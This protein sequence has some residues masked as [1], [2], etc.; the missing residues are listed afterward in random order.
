MATSSS[1]QLSPPIAARISE[2]ESQL[3]SLRRAE[4]QVLNSRAQTQA[5]LDNI[6]H[7]AWMKNTEGV[8]LAVNE[9]YAR[10]CGLPLDAVLG[11]TDWD[12][13]PPEL[14][15]RYVADDQRVM[16]SGQKVLVEEP[17]AWIDGTRWFETFKTPVID[18][19]QRVVGTV[20][21]AIDIT[22][23]RRAE[24]ERRILERQTLQA[25][26]LESL[27]LLAG[28]IA[29]DFNNLLTG[30]LTNA[31]LALHHLATS[32]NL[33]EVASRVADLKLAALH[34]SELTQQM[35]AYSGRGRFTVETL[36]LN[37]MVAEMS[38]LLRSSISKRAELRLDLDEQLP[39]VRADVAQLRQVIMNLLT[40]ASDAL[41]DEPGRI[42]IRTSAC[43]LDPSMWGSNDEHALPRG[44]Y[45]KLVVRDEG[46]GMDEITRAR[47]FEPFYT[48]KTT[49][50]GLG[51]SA[52]QGIV[53]GHGGGILVESAT[54]EGTTIT[55]LLPAI[56]ATAVRAS[57]PSPHAPEPS[58]GG[59]RV[60]VVDDDDRVRLVTGRL[61]RE[62]GFET[63][64]AESGRRGV[65]IFAE[66]PDRFRFALLD[67]TMPD[68][69]GDQ[70]FAALRAIR[71]DLP[72]LLCSGYDEHD[73]SRRFVAG[74]EP[75]FLQK[76][77]TFD[78]LA[79]RI[80]ETLA[81]PRE[82]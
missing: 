37:A 52:V 3:E 32:S 2:L 18:S 66:A 17:I 35:L 23:R 59:G 25:Q 29:H 1:D 19:K 36:S 57:T 68:M 63:V 6:P 20:G 56:E 78:A 82:S 28:G 48:T 13:W 58:L 62:L 43:E 49:G 71:S 12:L 80:A 72:V 76:P 4:E 44:T 30:I 5:L 70:V 54:G 47:L 77:Y 45:V 38:H 42:E 55:V 73:V 26:K 22:S 39:D 74:A 65:E 41:G 21:L 51:L 10:A 67:M 60:L 81:G 8:L 33:E 7:M 40:N 61:L 9:P 16:S 79:S 69:S 75:L 50:R 27:G 31:E 15:K 46:C 14:A 64:E 53:R 11:K 34:A 24:D